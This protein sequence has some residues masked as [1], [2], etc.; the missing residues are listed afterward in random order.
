MSSEWN[1]W[2]LFTHGGDFGVEDPQFDT[3]VGF[4]VFKLPFLSFVSGWLFA[5]L[6][7]VLIVTAVAH[8]LNGGIRVSSMG[9]RVTPAGEGPPVGA[10]RA[11]RPG[12]GGRL[13]AAALRAHGVDAGATSTAPATPT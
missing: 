13:L 10:P 4:Y 9:Q 12:E 3:D 8:Y 7:I 2:L 6:L 11:A 1:S 5:S